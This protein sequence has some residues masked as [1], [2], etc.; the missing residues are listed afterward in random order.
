MISCFLRL[1]WLKIPNFVF[2]HDCLTFVNADEMKADE[3]GE[4]RNTKSSLS[5]LKG[6]QR[7]GVLLLAEGYLALLDSKL[8]AA[9]DCLQEC[10]RSLLVCT[11]YRYIGASTHG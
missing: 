10:Q 7:S 9:R 5:Q 6:G 4:I 8:T 3:V 1:P 2:T 11:T